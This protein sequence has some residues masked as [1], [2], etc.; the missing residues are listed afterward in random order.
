MLRLLPWP[1]QIL[2]AVVALL[3]GYYD[4]RFR[5]IPNWLTLPTVL[6]GLA[7]NALLANPFWD[8]LKDA[9]LAILLAL[10]LNFPLYLLRAL[11]AGDVKLLAAIG[12]LVGWRDWIAIFWS[13]LLLAGVLAVILIV[14]SGRVGKTLRN[15]AAIVGEMVHLRAP[16]NKSPELDVRSQSSARLPLGAAIAL[17]CFAF[18]GFQ[19]FLTR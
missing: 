1:I 9:G 12:A 19:A 14:S 6:V 7:L 16:Y 11:G 13:S 17:G 8:G 5:R 3:A 4:I 15:V 10:A 18:V 2:L